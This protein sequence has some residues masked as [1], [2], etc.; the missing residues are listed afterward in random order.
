[1]SSP[2]LLKIAVRV[3]DK[4]LRRPVFARQKYMRPNLL[5]WGHVCPLSP[6]AGREPERGDPFSSPEEFCLTPLRFGCGTETLMQGFQAQGLTDNGITRRRR[7]SIREWRPTRR[8]C[9]GPH[10]TTK[11]D[12]PSANGGERKSGRVMTG[13]HSDKASV[14]RQIND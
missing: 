11:C 14:P 10:K 6:R 8:G 9:V 13:T 5:L 3:R 1:M 7:R 2:Q 4:I 12:V